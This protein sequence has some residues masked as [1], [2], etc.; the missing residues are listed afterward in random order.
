MTFVSLARKLK[1]P[2]AVQ[3]YL[4]RLPYNREPRGETLRSAKSALAKGQAHCLEAAFLAAAI[5][6]LHGY[7]PLVLSFESQDGLDHVI[8]AYQG[9]SGKWGSV[10]RSRDEGLHGRPAIFRS[11]RD[12]AWSY[13]EPYVDKTGR[14]TAYQLAHLDETNADWRASK[15]D[16]WKAE[17]YLLKLKHRPLKSSTTR[18]QKLRA[19]YLAN[20]PMKPKHFWW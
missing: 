8:F 13:F 4:R 7:P 18:H 5:L 1:T 11:V 2:K 16:V 14:I 10:A 6:E 3:A 12:L 20:G 19:A 15:A 9:K 17:T